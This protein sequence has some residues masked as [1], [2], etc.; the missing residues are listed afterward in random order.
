MDVLVEDHPKLV[1]KVQFS[2][3]GSSRP[4]IWLDT[5]IHAREWI[6]QATG[7]WTANKVTLGPPGVWDPNSY[8]A[9]VPLLISEGHRGSSCSS[10]CTDRQGI[11]AGP[12]CHGHPGQHGHLPGDCAGSSSNPCS[13][14]YHGPHAHSER[15]VRAIVD[16]IRAHGNV[17]SVI[18]IH[19]YSQMLL[20]PYGYRRAPA[21]D[22]QEMVRWP[23]NVGLGPLA[24]HPRSSPAPLIRCNLNIKPLHLGSGGGRL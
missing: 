1:S 14:T 7:V 8:P 4:A 23:Q 2:T 5:G 9:S 20:F 21:P 16:F 12:L 18:S 22:H 3:G 15:E 13:E 11:R 19:S 24:E 17:K 6:T 10:P